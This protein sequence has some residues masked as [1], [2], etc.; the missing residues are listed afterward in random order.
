MPYPICTDLLEDE[1][2]LAGER[3]T[4]GLYQDIASGHE[5]QFDTEDVLPASLN[6]RVAVYACV[7]H[8]WKQIEDAQK[9]MRITHAENIQPD[10]PSFADIQP[11]TTLLLASDHSLWCDSARNMVRNTE[12]VVVGEAPSCSKALEYA[13]SARPDIVLLDTGITGGDGLEQI[14]AFK[15]AHPS[16]A[17][18]LMTARVDPNFQGR[19]LSGGASGCLLKGM[20]HEALLDALRAIADGAMVL[21]DDFSNSP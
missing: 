11:K 5:I 21:T 19:A 8:T 4:P 7:R 13:L 15:E 16:T 6:G 12:F 9:P 2:Y 20:T 3:V 10:R 14:R 17:V 1:L 18:V